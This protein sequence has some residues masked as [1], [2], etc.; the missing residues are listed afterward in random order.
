[1]KL[2]YRGEL[3]HRES[4]FMTP[5]RTSN[6]RCG[7][8]CHN[9][10]QAGT[11][12]TGLL[13]NNLTELPGECVAVMLCRITHNMYIVNSQ[14]IMRFLFHNHSYSL[15][16]SYISYLRV[17]LT[18][19]PWRNIAECSCVKFESKFISCIDQFDSLI[20]SVNGSKCNW[21]CQTYFIYCNPGHPWWMPRDPTDI[22]LSFVYI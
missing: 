14:E 2:Y 11:G 12:L 1:M 20:H 16:A 6:C 13:F 3:L 9:L 4:C 15:Y 5:C 22:E 17:E 21:Q 18:H 7:L 10:F 8:F 19:A